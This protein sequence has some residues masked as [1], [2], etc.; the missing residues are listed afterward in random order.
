MRHDANGRAFALQ[1]RLLR[2]HHP[3]VNPL[4]LQSAPSCRGN[5]S[6]AKPGSVRTDITRPVTGYQA[7]SNAQ[8]VCPY[9]SILHPLAPRVIVL[10]L[11]LSEM[12]IETVFPFIFGMWESGF[13]YSHSLFQFINDDYYCEVPR[14]VSLQRRHVTKLIAELIF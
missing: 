7:A 5:S 11:S 6:P 9:I 4:R 13:W 8:E 3:R 12:K 10:S 1:S 14:K 2:M